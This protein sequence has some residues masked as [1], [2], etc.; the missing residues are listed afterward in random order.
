M[1]QFDQSAFAAPRQKTGWERDFRINEKTHFQSRLEIFMC[2]VFSGL[3]LWDQR[4][5]YRLEF[6]PSS[7]VQPTMFCKAYGHC[8]SFCYHGAFRDKNAAPRALSYFF[9]RI[10]M[11]ARVTS[12]SKFIAQ[13]SPALT[14]EIVKSSRGDSSFWTRMVVRVRSY[15]SPGYG[16]PHTGPP[17]SFLVFLLMISVHESGPGIASSV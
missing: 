13:P 15:C 16:I 7:P 12:Q 4:F 5:V 3:T 17:L 10:W 11:V 14:R 2:C 6:P 1:A 9:S 8:V